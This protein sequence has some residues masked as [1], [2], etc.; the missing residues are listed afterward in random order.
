MTIVVST[1]LG[2]IRV[3]ILPGTLM[4]G[5]ITF[6]PPESER[7]SSYLHDNRKWH[8]LLVAQQLHFFSSSSLNDFR[9]A[10]QK[11]LQKCCCQHT[12]E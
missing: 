4:T 1:L 7:T 11:D 6:L 3:R 8:L 10:C 5:R 9:L 12:L 2:L